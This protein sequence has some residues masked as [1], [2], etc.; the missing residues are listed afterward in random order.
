MKWRKGHIYRQYIHVYCQK[1]YSLY[2]RALEYKTTQYFLTMYMYF[3]SPFPAI[4]GGGGSFNNAEP[5]PLSR[6]NL[7]NLQTPIQDKLVQK[8]TP[9]IFLF[10]CTVN[11]YIHSTGN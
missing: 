9:Y 2:L 5:R 3:H 4:K 1:I 7:N 6:Q 11:N 8:F 10:K